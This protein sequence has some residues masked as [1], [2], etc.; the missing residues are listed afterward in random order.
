MNSLPSK[1]VFHAIRC[2]GR[3]HC[4]LAV[5]L[6]LVLGCRSYRDIPQTIGNNTDSIDSLM[7]QVDAGPP[8]SEPVE[9]TAQPMTL[10]SPE[11]FEN[12]QYRELSLQQAIETA[13]GNA[14]VLR[15]LGATVLRSPSLVTTTEAL[16]L[17][18]TDP[19]ASIEA[20]LSAYDAQVYGFG[21]WQNND[22]RFNNRF[23]GG[24]S[25]AFKQ[26]THDYVLQLSK[27][28]ATGAQFALRSVTDYDANN[29]TGNLFPSAW[30]SQLHAEMRQPLMQGGGL[31]FN[32]IAGPAAQ[33]GVYNGILIAKVNSDITAAKFRSQTRDFVSNVIN[34]YWDLYFAYRDLDAKA[35]A[36]ERSRETWESYQ[37][38]KTSSRKSGAAEALARE[39]YYRFKSELQDAIAGK[40]TQRTQVN[41]SSTGGTF[42][43]IGGVQAAERRLRLL[44]GFPLSDGTLIR[45]S[46]E[47]NEA[48]LVFDWDSI[49]AEAIQLRSEL[50]QQRLTVKR[51]EMELLAA[52]N[53]LMPSL[54]L[55]SIY[56]LRGLDQ[57]LAGNDSALEEVGTFDYQ[58]YEASLELR[59]P[60]GFRQGHAA[61]RH[62][63]FQ[64]SREKAIL[65]EQER[66]ILHDLMS[67]VAD[68]DRAYAQM[69][70]NMNRYIAASEALEVLQAN[71]HAG[72]PVNLEQLLDSQRRISEAQS[73]YFLSLAEYTVASKNVQFE[74]GTLLQMANMVIADL[75]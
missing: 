61:V 25:T 21:K 8:P 75:P 72:L 14:Q 68:V 43:G 13:L 9:W 59:L 37:A 27:R 53:F 2:G 10:R 63:R 60:V 52:K 1:R 17:V 36:L 54:D 39:Q 23:F 5:G 74:K 6:V 69:Q 55:V 40:L 18:Q 57:N 42:A 49:S 64:I 29:A 31:T 19:Q 44:I 22:R 41:Q 46:D 20:A 70:T 4:A 71:R 62:A 35:A 66:Q 15:D 67:V 48:P 45:P 7:Q 33:P 50:Q 65:Q 56:R 28:T 3:W 47:P 11:D 30:Q 51:R 73:R 12:A 38:Q 26:D 58:E 32:R 34:A 16:G 24:G